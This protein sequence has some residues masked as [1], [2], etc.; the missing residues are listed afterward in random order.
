MPELPEVE[1]IARKLAP[2]LANQRLANIQQHHPKSLHGDS[3]AL[4]GKKI[5]SVTRRAKIIRVQLQDELN[6]LIHLKMTGQLIYQDSSQRVGG[7]HPTADWVNELPGKHTRVEITL[8]SG[9]KLYFNDQRLFGWLK[10]MTDEAVAAVYSALAPDI[11]DDAVTIEYWQG[12]LSRRKQAV[13][14]VIMDNAVVCGIG[15]IYACDALNVAMISPF[16]PASSLTP[17]KMQNLLIAAKSVIAQGVK[18]GGTTFDGKYVDVHGFAGQYQS[19]VRVY[20]REGKA[21]VNCGEKIVKMQLGG[22]G[23]YFC[24]NCQKS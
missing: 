23:T 8:D 15:N 13:K 17:A 6:I 16:A 5:L 20:G 14:Q 1:T 7:G 9:A 10:I 12:K 2:L 11:T 18:L 24:P 19:V 21:C 4:V 22:R 3:A